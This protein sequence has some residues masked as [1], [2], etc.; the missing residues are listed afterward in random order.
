MKI[1][2]PGSISPYKYAMSISS[3]NGIRLLV[4]VNARKSLTE[5]HETVGLK[6][7]VKSIPSIWRCHSRAPSS[8]YPGLTQIKFKDTGD[9]L[10]NHFQSFLPLCNLENAHDLLM[11]SILYTTGYSERGR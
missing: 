3:C 9:T 7:S 8:T 1:T 4:T 5:F 10:V 11:V 6:V 2:T